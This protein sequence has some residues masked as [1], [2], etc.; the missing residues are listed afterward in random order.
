MTGASEQHGLLLAMDTATHSSVVALGRPEPLAMSRREAQH[1]H[2]VHLLE[3]VDEVLA[4]AG[5]AAAGLAAGPF[6][7][8]VVGTGPGSFTGLR[9]G[10]ATAKT[11]AHV[12]A[13]PLIGIATAEAL[14]NA[15]SGIAARSS[16]TPGDLAVV[17]PA[18]ASDHYLMRPGE[19]PLLVPPGELREA[20]GEGP[21]I[22]VD[23]GPE[24]LGAEA[25]RL[26]DRAVE[27][28]AAALLEI[29]AEH[30]AAGRFDDPA[31]LVPT[32]VA[33]PRGIRKGAEELGWSPDL[34]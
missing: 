28:L 7:G 1:R 31:T 4:A 20:V 23:I 29:G 2:G 10:L 24:L 12:R 25:A 21:A 16:A 30:L 9:V 26:G 22:A 5:L 27:G 14:R 32:Y 13:I 17:L 34:R 19:A 8:L 33:L 18:G 6:A 11:I 3:Q 15:A